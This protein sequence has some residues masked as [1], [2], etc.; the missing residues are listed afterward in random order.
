MTTAELLARLELRLAQAGLDLI[1]AF[2]VRTL[3][4]GLATQEREGQGS[5]FRLPLPT[6]EEDALGVVIGNTRALWEPFQRAR[7]YEEQHPL[8]R[9]IERSI[10]AVLDEVAPGLVHSVLFAHRGTPAPVPLQRIAH[11]AGLAPL[12]P[13]GLNVHP[14]YGPWFALRGVLV[15]H[16]APIS[17][18]LSAPPPCASCNA[19]CRAALTRALTSAPPRE[20]SLPTPGLTPEQQ[21]FL[22][23]RG[24][25][26]IGVE[27]RYSVEQIQFHYGALPSSSPKGKKSQP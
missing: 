4:E 12:G 19:P 27:Q 26:P 10:E 20:W 15:F 6:E 14:H 22:E 1:Q 8:D 24:V 23:V 17:T 7:R 13:A 16:R 2:S 9:Y 11:L 3:N 5:S 18:P 25:C 21:L